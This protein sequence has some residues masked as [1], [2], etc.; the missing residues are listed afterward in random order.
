MKK[1]L[2]DKS[3][4]KSTIFLA[5]RLFM[6]TLVVPLY[7]YFMLD[8]L[9][10]NYQTVSLL[11]VVQTV[12]MMLGLYVCGNLNARFAINTLLDLTD[13]CSILLSVGINLISSFA[14]RTC[15]LADFARGRRRWIQSISI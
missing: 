6:Q 5:A 3:F 2:R 4:M 1:P 12:S 15:Y 8:L 11:M 9:H 13:H 7:S 14:V 10:I